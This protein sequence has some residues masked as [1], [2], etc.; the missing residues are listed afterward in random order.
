MR[1]LFTL[2]SLSVI[3]SVSAQNIG[4]SYIKINELTVDS[5]L[6]K[7]KSN[8]TPAPASILDRKKSVICEE[9]ELE[10]YDRH[11]ILKS[12]NS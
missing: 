4:L 3:F 10:S 5:F 12:Q 9:I 8:A 7:T 1:I 2:L 6:V 11:E